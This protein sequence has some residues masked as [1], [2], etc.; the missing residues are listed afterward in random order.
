MNT[1]VHTVSA[2]ED[3]SEV[4]SKMDKHRLFSMPVISNNRFIGMISKATL[5]DQYRKEL[6]VQT[7]L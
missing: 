6:R 2:D 5:L 1:R 4:L 7:S 3:L